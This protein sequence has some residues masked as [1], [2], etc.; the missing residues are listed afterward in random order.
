LAA[1]TPGGLAAALLYLQSPS[2]LRE[3][4]RRAPAAERDAAAKRRPLLSRIAQEADDDRLEAWIRLER[5]VWTC[6]NRERYGRYQAAWKLFFRRWRAEPDW[7]WP[8]AEPF[9]RQHERLVAAARRHEL[10]RDPLA[11]LDASRLRELAIAK[12]ATLGL[13]PVE[14]VRSVAPGPDEV[15]T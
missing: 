9:A 1:A 11:D 5:L 7:A 4:W 12:A 10:T 8:T 13:Q 2:R 6:I 3:V 15:L 14:N